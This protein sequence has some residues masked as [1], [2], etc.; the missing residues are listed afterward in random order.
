MLS[1]A[2]ARKGT[3]PVPAEVSNVHGVHTLASRKR[4]L[5]RHRRLYS[6]AITQSSSNTYAGRTVYVQGKRTL[7]NRSGTIDSTS[8]AATLLVNASTFPLKHSR[9]GEA[10]LASFPSVL[11]KRTSEVHNPTDE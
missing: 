7:H 6:T 4:L 9:H 2:L 10:P 5:Q 11:N 8:Q 1:G 3:T